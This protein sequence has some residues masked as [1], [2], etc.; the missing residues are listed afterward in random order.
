MRLLALLLF[1]SLL[2]SGTTDLRKARDRQDRQAL[3]RMVSQYAT[4][5]KAKPNDADAQYRLAL[6]HSYLAEVAIEQHDKARATTAAENGIDAAQRAVAINAGSAEYNRLLGTLCGQ[7]ISSAG[8]MGLRY[9][10]CALD[11]VNKAIEL[12]P[13]DPENYVSH[14]VGMYYLPAAFGGGVD[15]A[16][17]DFREAIGLDPKT[18]DAWLWLGIALRKQNHDAE[19]RKAFEKALALDPDRVWIKEQLD[20]TPATP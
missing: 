15:L 3:E 9:G 4:T 20:K 17:K 8:F 18:T 16:I 2:N 12:N 7:A 11:S 5:A 13:K 10:K 19:A 1:G 6:A 14:G